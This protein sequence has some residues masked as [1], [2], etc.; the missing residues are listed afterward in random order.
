MNFICYFNPGK[1]SSVQIQKGGHF[2]SKSY[3]GVVLEGMQVGSLLTRRIPLWTPLLSRVSCY[4]F[5]IPSKIALLHVQKFFIS[6]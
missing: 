1:Y 5:C 3:G 6:V 4:C 2:L